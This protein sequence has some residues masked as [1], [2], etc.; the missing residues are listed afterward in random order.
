MKTFL[1]LT[2]AAQAVLLYLREA[3]SRA[4]DETAHPKLYAHSRSAGGFAS[5][6]RWEPSRSVTGPDGP[7]K[8]IQ[9]VLGIAIASRCQA[10]A[11]TCFASC[12]DRIAR[13]KRG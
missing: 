9:A 11:L 12:L 2:P 4:G 3:N 13:R 1:K 5:S 10:M 8:L 6:M 7:R